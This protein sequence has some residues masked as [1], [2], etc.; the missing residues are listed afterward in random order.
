VDERTLRKLDVPQ[1]GLTPLK[2]DDDAL[3][4][5]EGVNQAIEAFI[6]DAAYPFKAAYRLT[7]NIA[8]D[9]ALTGKLFEIVYVKGLRK[10]QPNAAL[11]SIEKYGLDSIN[12]NEYVLVNRALVL[13]HCECGSR[14]GEVFS[15][16]DAPVSARQTKVNGTIEVIAVTAI[17]HGGV[18]ANPDASQRV[19]PLR[20]NQV[21]KIVPSRIVF[22]APPNLAVRED[23]G[24]TISRP[25]DNRAFKSIVLHVNAHRQ[26]QNVA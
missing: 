14:A 9:A 5:G 4:G 2:G 19:F 7:T 16:E 1:L 10:S 25:S 15:G 23:I 3:S 8:Y 6:P 11:H 17:D 18:N 13:G 24:R 12:A 22:E 21:V 26:I 20:P